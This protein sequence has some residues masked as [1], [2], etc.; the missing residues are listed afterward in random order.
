MKTNQQKL[1]KSQVEITFELDEQEFS[2][3]IDKALEHLKS[4]VK[5]DGFRKGKVP[6]NMIEEKV[7][8]ESLLMEAGDI[9]V[10]ESYG[11]YVTDNNLE[12]IGPPEVQIKKIAKGNPF[13]FTVKIEVLPDVELPDYKTIASKVKGLEVS[14]SPQEVDDAIIYLQKSRAK[15]SQIDRPAEKKDFIEINYSNEHINQGKEIKDKFVL[16]DGGFQPG[17]E[18]NMVGMNV[19]DKKE[20]VSRFPDNHPDKSL[21]GKDATFK[22][23]L[24]SVQK[25]ELPEINDQ[26][27]KELGAF[28]TLVALKE[29]IKEGVAVEKK[30]SERQRKRGD[31]LESISKE[32][33][34]ELPEKM[35][36]YEQ[37]R[38]FEN[39]KTQMTQNLKI[40]FEE[41]LSSIEKTEEEIKASY[42][43]EAE[44]RIK[45]FLILRQM[46]RTE[47][48][49]VSDA[50]IQ[51]EM[52]KFVRSYSKEQIDKIDIKQ[53]KEY[54]KD[55]IIN[56]KIFQ[57]LENFSQK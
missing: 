16:G 42:R 25:M 20:F 56:E 23:E 32:A 5:M 24:V 11:K 1:E 14:V 4:H 36:I 30:E 12:P 44:K 33:K 7:G 37:G 46:A 47:K 41:Y 17:F 48:V 18:D 27:A 10:K 9:A 43:L 55:T 13:L 40:T 53:L 6:A 35:V 19:G 22:V 45:G 52:N 34:F 49:E 31:I 51:E 3:Y 57:Q 38:L 50:E 2:K 29:N 8:A 54:T 21:A 28:D 15:F 39:L 26:F